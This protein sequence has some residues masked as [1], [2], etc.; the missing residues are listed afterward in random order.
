M[1]NRRMRLPDDQ[2]LKNARNYTIFRVCPSESIVA[3]STPVFPGSAAAGR[4]E[5]RPFTL[6]DG[7]TRLC[8]GL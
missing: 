4:L 1:S 8:G 5:L 3:T 6:I 7:E 2:S